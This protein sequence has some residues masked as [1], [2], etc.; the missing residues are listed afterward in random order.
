MVYMM[1]LVFLHWM[2]NMLKHNNSLPYFLLL[3]FSPPQ[4]VSII[5]YLFLKIF[6]YLLILHN[7]LVFIIF[8]TINIIYII[9]V[10]ITIELKIFTITSAPLI[11]TCCQICPIKFVF[12][13]NNICRKLNIKKFY[14]GV[15]INVTYVIN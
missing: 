5:S 2:E 3:E 6:R 10:L 8:L 4:Y 1:F 7:W 13:C 9:I 14:D 12:R 15:I 11:S